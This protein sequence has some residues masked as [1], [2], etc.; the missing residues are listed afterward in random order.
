LL[1]Y[2]A[3]AIAPSV[4]LSTFG[5]K[6]GG[7]AGLTTDHKV[8]II[9]GLIAAIGAIIAALVTGCTASDSPTVNQKTGGNGNV[10][11]NSKC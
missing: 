8:A 10:C 4:S 11:I 6:G 5:L 7:M 2:G 9:V 3:F 1:R